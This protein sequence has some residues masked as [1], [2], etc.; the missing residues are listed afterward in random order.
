[1]Q[2][3]IMRHGQAEPMSINDSQR[4]LT[5]QGYLEA[6]K[7][8]KWMVSHQ[9]APEQVFVSPYIRAQQT[10]ETVINHFNVSIRTK[11]LDFITP[12]GNAKEVHDYLDG[13][14]Q[15][16]NLQ[17]VLI[18]SHMP[19]VSY[20]VS[21][22]TF[23]NQSPIFQTAAIAQIDYDITSMKGSLVRLISPNEVR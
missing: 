6:D 16:Q 7:M 21:E 15:T 22:L 19:L 4:E 13:F 14:C 18:V 12:T 20:L 3:F 17:R 5:K 11:T 1:M 23:D 10:A 9:L 8:A 2:L